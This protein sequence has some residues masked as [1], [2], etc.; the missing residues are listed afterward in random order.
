M[1]H[2]WFPFL[3]VINITKLERLHRAASHVITDCLSPFP[4]PL[5][6]SEAPLPP[7]QVTLTHFTLSSY[8]WALHL[9][10]FFPMSD[11]ARLGVTPRL[12]IVLESLCVH[13]PAHTSFYLFEEGPSR[14]PYLSS[15]K[16]AF[17]YC[18]VRPFLFLLPL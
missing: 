13:S 16:S 9:P 7:L 14:M 6:L 2:P 17:F 18:G 4:I 12:Q 11:L 15:L 10:T 3:S 1:L 5:L 8:E